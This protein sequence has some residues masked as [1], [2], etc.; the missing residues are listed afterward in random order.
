MLTEQD[1][2]NVL[3]L[4][5]ANASGGGPLR[6]GRQ[7]RGALASRCTQVP[8]SGPLGEVKAQACS[9]FNDLHAAIDSGGGPRRSPLCIAG[10]DGSVWATIEKLNGVVLKITTAA[11]ARIPVTL[12]TVF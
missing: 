12:R 3:L 2:F 7:A 11:N 4:Q 10:G 1:A 5:A 6:V 9:A 8:V